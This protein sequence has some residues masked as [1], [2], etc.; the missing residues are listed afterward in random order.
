MSPVAIT[1][2]P[3]AHLTAYAP[4]FT[5]GGS[6]SKEKFF[7][8]SEHLIALFLWLCLAA[9]ATSDAHHRPLPFS[10]PVI[11]LNHKMLFFR[12]WLSEDGKMPSS[13]VDITQEEHPKRNA[14]A[15]LM[16]QS[17][18]DFVLNRTLGET[19]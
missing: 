9:L 16:G 15:A 2:R 10:C 1:S 5:A 4:G 13:S 12:I 19:A 18:K 17:A 11:H 3:Q 8:G 7:D 14:I 6:V